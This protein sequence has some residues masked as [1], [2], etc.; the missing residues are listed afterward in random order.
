[1]ASVIRYSVVGSISS[2]LQGGGHVGDGAGEDVEPS[3]GFYGGL[4]FTLLIGLA[5]AGGFDFDFEMASPRQ[6]ALQVGRTREPE[7]DD[8]GG[9]ER[10][11]D[12]GIASPEKEEAAEVIQDRGL[13]GAFGHGAE[14]SYK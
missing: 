11:P 5:T 6:D 7:G 3:G 4:K 12:A 10:Q 9:V 8:A 2:D 14:V 13:D 1:M